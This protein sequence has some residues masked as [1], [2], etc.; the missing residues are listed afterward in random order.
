MLV[1]LAY[2]AYAL[3]LGTGSSRTACMPDIHTLSRAALRASRLHDFTPAPPQPSSPSPHALTT[4]SLR[5][6][7]F[8][9]AVTSRPSCNIHS[10][11]CRCSSAS[12]PRSP[13]TTGA[14]SRPCAAHQGKT[15][16]PAL[17]P[18]LRARE[19]HQQRPGRPPARPI[20]QIDRARVVVVRPEELPAA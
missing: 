15:P 1:I 9:P 18:R 5:K 12:P 17:T 11:P 3:A 2:A 6:T 20:R 10:R 16:S 13:A 14:A 19:V 7:H 8:S 4:K